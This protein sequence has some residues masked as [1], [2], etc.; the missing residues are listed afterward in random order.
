LAPIA[1]ASNPDIDGRTPT[2]SV[3]EGIASPHV[4]NPAL[5]Y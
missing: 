1:G 2:H 4:N 5:V 3:T